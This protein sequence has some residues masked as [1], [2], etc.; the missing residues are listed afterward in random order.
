MKFLIDGY[1]RWSHEL[2]FTV[3]DTESYCTS[4]LI[5]LVPVVVKKNVG[6][7]E[8]TCM[9]AFNMN[10]IFMNDIFRP[11]QRTLDVAW[12]LI[13]EC[14]LLTE[15][16]KNFFIRDILSFSNLT[17]CNIMLDGNPILMSQKT[18]N[19]MYTLTSPITF[20]VSQPVE[21]EV[22]IGTGAQCV[23][24]LLHYFYQD[25]SYI[26]HF[27]GCNLFIYCLFS[28]QFSLSQTSVGV[29]SGK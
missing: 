3:K 27:Y 17:G 9:F 10:I 20:I 25:I 22:F 24:F 13:S 5:V 23:L 15:D 7:C 29:Y 11:I 21:K 16:M 6:H 1:P 2:D 14:T 8:V 18:G 4:V 26:S 28:T 12:G 19:P